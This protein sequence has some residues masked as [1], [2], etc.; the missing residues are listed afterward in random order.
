M[1]SKESA[2][3]LSLW[4]DVP[5]HRCTAQS[6]LHKHERTRS[7]DLAVK[8]PAC[9]YFH[10]SSMNQRSVTRF[11]RLKIVAVRSL[12][13][14]ALLHLRLFS[15]TVVKV[16]NSPILKPTL[17]VDVVNPHISGMSIH[18]ASGQ[19]FLREI[20]VMM[21]APVAEARE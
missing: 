10:R 21:E 17:K 9:Q 19:R 4:L 20:P 6:R 16:G 5:Y 12:Q 8:R 1:N 7:G 13:H 14:N 2:T 11:A 3:G 18:Y 15:A